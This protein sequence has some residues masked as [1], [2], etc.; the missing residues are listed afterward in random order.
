MHMIRPMQVLDVDQVHRIE[1]RA[2]RA[3]WSRSIINDCVMVGYDC[4]VLEQVDFRGKTIVGYI[5]SRRSD[6]TYHIL[7]LCIDTNQQRKGLGKFLLKSVL[8]SLTGS[9]LESVM[10]E[11]RP[12]NQAAITLYEGFGF[13]SGGIKKNYYKDDKSTEDALV[14]IKSM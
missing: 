8:N 3:P 6:N 9:G 11:V 1:L 13:Q 14:L 7:N 12:T 10:L 2:H 4:R 5:I